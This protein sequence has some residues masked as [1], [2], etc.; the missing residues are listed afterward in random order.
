MTYV[1]SLTFPAPTLG[2]SALLPTLP[3]EI[4]P[5]REDRLFELYMAGQCPLWL[6]QWKE[7]VV[8]AEGLKGSFFVLPDFLCLGTDTDYL[9]TP[10]GALNAERILEQRFNAVLP[11]ERMVDLIYAASKR[12]AAQP[13]GPPYDDSMMNTSRWPAQ[14]AKVIGM[15]RARGVTTGQLVEGHCK[16]VI[17]SDKAMAKHGVHLGFYGWFLNNGE[18]I[19]QDS[20]EHGALYCDYSHGVRG[21]L[22]TVVVEDQTMKLADALKDERAHVLFSS[23]RFDP[24]SYTA[25][26]A[27]YFQMRGV[28]APLT[29]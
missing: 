9:Y 11:T 29:Y 13:W 15:Q 18:P 28:E 4:G 12:Q 3:N 16:N 8:E 25:A 2:C 24:G 14:S 20:L 10:M 1:D 23:T 6:R 22:S 5:A 21:V 26:R 17:V 27:A 7:I 19:Q